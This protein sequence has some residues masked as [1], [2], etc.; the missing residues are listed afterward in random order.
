MLLGWNIRRK[1]EEYCT[2]GH[3]GTSLDCAVCYCFPELIRTI[4][5]RVHV[6]LSNHFLE[7]CHWR[8]V[9]VHCMPLKSS[10]SV[11][12]DQNLYTLPSTMKRVNHRNIRFPIWI[13]SLKVS[14]RR[15]VKIR[16]Y[17]TRKRHN[18]QDYI[19]QQLRSQPY[20][21]VQ[22]HTRQCLVCRPWLS[23][24]IIQCISHR[25]WGWERLWA[26]M[27]TDLMSDSAV[28]ITKYYRART[29]CQKQK[30]FLGRT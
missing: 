25:K 20:S 2:G 22:T 9:F 29:W 21:A 12:C 13:T 11:P 8:T 5:S 23:E 4:L 3:S 18:D 24:S 17:L 28:L 16:L 6:F 15:F 7:S 1:N 30:H 10:E 26:I 27:V 19:L 14:Q